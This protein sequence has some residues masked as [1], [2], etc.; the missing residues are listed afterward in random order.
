MLTK[1]WMLG[2]L[3]FGLLG[4]VGC[5]PTDGDT[6]ND[7]PDRAE[8]AASLS[9]G[10][11]DDALINGLCERSGAEPGCD[12]CGELDLYG[13]GT[14]DDFCPTHD[15]ADCG[16]MV[17]SLEQ[18]DPSELED[19][20]FFTTNYTLAEAR[21]E[22][23]E[24][25]TTLRFGGGCQEH[26]FALCWDGD[27]DAES[28]DLYLGHNSNNDFCEAFLAEE[29][30]FEL[31][32]ALGSQPASLSIVGHD[33]TVEYTGGG[34]SGGSIPAAGEV[35]FCDEATV[36]ALE[37][38]GYFRDP[39]SVQSLAISGNKLDVSLA[40]GGGCGEHD[41]R[42]CWD[43]VVLESFPPQAPLTLFHNPNGD[44]CEAFLSSE[45]SLGLGVFGTE[46]D[47]YLNLGEHSVLYQP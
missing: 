28:I 22:G 21:I 15:T 19:A 16:A 12:L 17:R 41:F 43:G 11:A 45:I 1:K 9:G 24:L 3:C 23:T 33:T 13:D 10:K 35:A 25:V 5:T 42:V 44:F 34:A 26:D 8:L 47:I 7:A 29:V 39:G 4:A 37:D 14:C 36:K 18:C 6:T 32:A 27:R 20:G 46:G 31:G 38:A 40:Y 30:R 2:V